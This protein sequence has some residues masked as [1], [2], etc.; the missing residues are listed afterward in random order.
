MRLALALLVMAGLAIAPAYAKT[1]IKSE[2]PSV[3]LL[4]AC[5]KFASGDVLIVEWATEHGWTASETESG[6]VFAHTYNA[7]QT[8][9][10]IGD[11]TLYALMETYP[12]QTL[13]YCRADISGPAIDLDIAKLGELPRLKGEV[14]SNERGTFGNWQGAE[15]G[16]DYLL[17][18][19]Q[20]DGAFSLQLTLFTARSG[21]AP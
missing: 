9:A 19:S 11:V 18:A 20:A 21:A 7:T 13:G 6:T 12:S 16:R 3:A 1:K 15:T 4:E 10:G 2:A 8:L 5:E 17:L 14:V